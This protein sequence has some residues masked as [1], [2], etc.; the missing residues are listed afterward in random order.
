MEG[1]AVVVLGGAAVVVVI[2]VVVRTVVTGVE[3]DVGR[4]VELTW[5]TVDE[6]ELLT[7]VE[8]IGAGS[9]IGTGAT[10]DVDVLLS[11][12]TV[13]LVT[14]VELVALVV[15]LATELVTSVLAVL[16]TELRMMEVATTGRG[17]GTVTE[18]DALK[19]EL[20]GVSVV[21]SKSLLDGPGDDTAG[22]DPLGATVAT[23]G[24]ATTTGGT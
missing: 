12:A 23:E 24:T 4:L 9:E 18:V 11:A 13:V 8:E 14:S 15:E 10:V 1:T 19:V 2:G 3:D 6:E 17:L 7:K 21:C 5:P 22:D 20:G 16:D